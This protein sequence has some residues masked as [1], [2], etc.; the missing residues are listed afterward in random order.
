MKNKMNIFKVL[1]NEIKEIK[2]VPA[3]DIA[4]QTIFSFIV[5]VITMT[6]FAAYDLGIQTLLSLIIK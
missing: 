3:K 5:L 2:W 6:I 1:K 4:R